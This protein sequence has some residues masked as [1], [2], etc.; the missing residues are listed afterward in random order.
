MSSFQFAAEVNQVGSLAPLD[1][2]PRGKGIYYAQERLSAGGTLSRKK[3]YARLRYGPK[4]TPELL[5]SLKA[6]FGL[7]AADTVEG[8]FKL[9]D[10]GTWV[11]KNG[12][13]SQP[14]LD[15]NDWDGYYWNDVSFYVAIKGDAS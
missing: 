3:P 13:I 9:D 10:D 6:Q 5:N 15:P 12:K 14:E 1:P 2:Q 8:T 11:N 7:D 4:I